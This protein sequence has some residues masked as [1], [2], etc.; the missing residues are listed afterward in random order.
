M[1][2][3]PT[4]LELRILRFLWDRPGGTTV[5]DILESWRTGDTPLYTTV[6]KTL[7]IMENKGIV[8]HT[9]SGRAYSYTPLIRKE[10][11][12]RG[13]FREL[14]ENIFGGDKLS[15]ANALVRELEFDGA[16]LESLQKMA[17]EMKTRGKK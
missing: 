3:G 5:N 7:Q 9:R 17:A 4:E 11:A 10:D 8:T 16:D 15:L 1:K 6:L 14:L 12:S 13:R 2:K